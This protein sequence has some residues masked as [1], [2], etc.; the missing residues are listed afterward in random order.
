MSAVLPYHVECKACL[1]TCPRLKANAGKIADS[2]V[3]GNYLE[4]KNVRSKTGSEH[5][6]NGGA[7]TA[8]LAATLEEELVDCAMVMGLDYWSPSGFWM[9]LPSDDEAENV[10]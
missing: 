7:A 8:L 2:N 3:L 6:Q 9:L 4:I 10:V 5:F 1:D